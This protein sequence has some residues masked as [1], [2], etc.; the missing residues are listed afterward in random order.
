[1]YRVWNVKSTSY[2][3]FFQGFQNHDLLSI[4]WS[5]QFNILL[6]QGHWNSKSV[7]F[8][9]SKRKYD[10][11]YK[12]LMN[13]IRYNKSFWFYLILWDTLLYYYCYG[14][15]DLKWKVCM[16]SQMSFH[17]ILCI[18]AFNEAEECKEVSKTWGG[19]T[20]SS[21]Y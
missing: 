11:V 1:M 3:I 14:W 12:L 17:S 13:N 9:K 15:L 6:D 19:I 7:N 10:T 18:L 5:S 2:W 16:W 8:R 21:F 20:S 4:N